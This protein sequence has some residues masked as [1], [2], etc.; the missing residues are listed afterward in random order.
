MVGVKVHVAELGDNEV[1]D[2]GL[3]HFLD[4]GLKFKELEA[5]SDVF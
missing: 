4:L 1:K 3:A 2:I 5:R